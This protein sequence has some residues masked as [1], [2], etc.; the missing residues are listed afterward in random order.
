V[1]HLIFFYG[2]LMAPF[3][4]PGRIRVDPQLTFKG[5][6]SIG[7]A[8]FDLGLY[9]AAVSADNDTTRVRGE[10]YEMSN[11]GAVLQVLDEIEGYRVAEPAAS[12]YSRRLTPVTLDDGHTVDAWAYFYDARLEHAER[13]DSGDYLQYLKGR[14]G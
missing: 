14:Q 6:G 10:V 2:T 1:S 3:N 8:L 9:P 12:R 13:I 7:A 4:R 11:A 5:H